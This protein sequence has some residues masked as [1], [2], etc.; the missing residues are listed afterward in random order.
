[1]AVKVTKPQINVREKLTEL[2]VPQIDYQEGEFTYAFTTSTSGSFTVRSGYETGRY[3]KVGNTCTI[4]LR[5]ESTT[6][7]SAAGDIGISGFPFPLADSPTGGTASYSFPTLVRGVTAS[8]QGMPTF[9]MLGGAT[10]GR[11]IYL[12]NDGTYT[13][14]TGSNVTGN[15]EGTL[16]FT[17]I[18]G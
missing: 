18:T 4:N 17:Y 1:M 11:F 5:F 3:V 13:G 12:A 7:N 15:I 10:E 14:I 2:N 16:T 9:L 8:D 6:N